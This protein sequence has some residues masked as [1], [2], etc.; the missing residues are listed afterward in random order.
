MSPECRG[1]FIL[2]LKDKNEE[3]DFGRLRYFV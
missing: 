2:N 3:N 1:R